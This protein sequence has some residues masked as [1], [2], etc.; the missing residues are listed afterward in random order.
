MS[1]TPSATDLRLEFIGPRQT[2]LV[3]SVDLDGEQP[4]SQVAQRL[5]ELEDELEKEP[6]VRE[7]ILTLATKDEPAI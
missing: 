4:E 1:H 2:Y 6:Y 3:V 7:A 5:R